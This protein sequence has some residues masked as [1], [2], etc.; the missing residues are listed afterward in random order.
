MYAGLKCPVPVS[1]EHT[2]S[3][4]VRG[5]EIGCAIAVE[6]TNGHRARSDRVTRWS[7]KS[8]V[9]VTQ[10][11]AYVTADAVSDGKIGVA[12][13]I[14]IAYSYGTDRNI[15]Q[16]HVAAGSVVDSRLKSS[17]GNHVDGFVPHT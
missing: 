5:D 8:P 7:L 9:P 11:Y 16:S 17:S 15:A 3:A 14:E 4:A 2:D 10:K 13:R 1:Y 6:I 12:V